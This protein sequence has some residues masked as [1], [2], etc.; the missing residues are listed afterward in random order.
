MSVRFFGQ[1]FVCSCV[2]VFVWA[3]FFL[4]HSCKFASF[5]CISSYIRLRHH[6][7]YRHQNHNCHHH[8]YH[9]HH[10]Q[11]HPHHHH[12]IGTVFLAL[13]F[14]LDFVSLLANLFGLSFCSCKFCLDIGLCFCSCAFAWNLFL[15]LHFAWILFLL[16]HFCLNFVSVFAI[17]FGHFF[18]SCKCCLDFVF[19]LA[20]CLLGLCFCSCTFAWVLFLLLHFLVVFSS[21]IFFFPL[22]RFRFKLF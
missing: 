18:C 21:C 13:H 17:L 10:H 5:V 9:Y 3:W 11:H 8:H 15:F 1:N 14:C 20:L 7:R 4:L 19:V 22:L 6:C 2:S 16:L 12:H